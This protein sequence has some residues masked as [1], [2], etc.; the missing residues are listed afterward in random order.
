MI[1]KKRFRNFY[2]RFISLQGEPAQIAAGFAIGVFV[3]VTPT[4]P[5][6]T[7]I[8]ILIAL[9]F[10]HNITAAYLGS[11]FISNPLTIPLFYLS[12][13]ELGRF[14]LGMERCRFEL[15]DYSLGTIAALGWKILLPL[16]TG[17]ILMAPFFS[18]PAYF[19]TRRLITSM[20]ARGKR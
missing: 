8:I 7:A 9:L 20:R 18:V 14:L 11:W 15:T 12:Q 13:Y 10:R 2:E 6:H 4:I 1:F 17:G 3:G 19:V 5:F 16:L